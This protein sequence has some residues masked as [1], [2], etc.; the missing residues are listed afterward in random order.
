M[1]KMNA[2][3]FSKKFLVFSLANLVCMAVSASQIEQQQ[4]KNL[5]LLPI[6]SFELIY[7]ADFNGMQIKA[8]HR[9]TPLGENQFEEYF[10][11]KGILGKVTETELFDITDNEIIVPL[12]NTYR[13]SLIGT[14]R[15]EKQQYDWTNNQVTYS[16]GKKSEQIPLKPGYLD[17]MSHKQQLRRDMAAGKNVLTYAVISRGKLKQ[18]TYQVIADEVLSTP[19]GPLDTRLIQRTNDDGTQTTKVW[20][21]K[22]WDFIMIRLERSD[23]GETQKMYFSSG[24]LGNK[25]IIPMVIDA[26]K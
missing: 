14:K 8:V 7:E 25:T 24:Q 20:L 22:D 2:S 1:N 4:E 6:K 19:I 12:E 11:A 13:R 26:E 15:T 21:A 10:E 18:Y 5:T 23:Q 16:K 3:I 17:S 9:L